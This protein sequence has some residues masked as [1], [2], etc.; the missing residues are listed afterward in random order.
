M[1]LFSSQTGRHFE[2]LASRMRP[3]SLDEYIGQ[4]HIVGPGRLLRRAIRADQLTSIIL[5]GPPGTG[6]TTLARVIA[7]TTKSNF[8]T[9]NAVLS[10]VKQIR[11]TVEKAQEQLSLYDQ[12]TILFVDEVHRWNK[13]QQDALLPWVENG[14]VIL[15]GATIENPYFEVNRALVSRSRIFQLKPLTDKN[16]FAI[17]RFTLSNPERGYGKYKVI[18]DDDALSHLVHV[19]NGD[20]RSL[21][22]ALELAVETTPDHFPPQ[23]GE[24]IHITLEIAEQSIQRK[25]VLYDKEGDYHFDTISAFIKSLR[26]SDPDAALYWLA[27]MIYAGEE[28][29]FI[30]R[31]MLIFACE[32][33]GMADPNALIVTEAAASAFER[34]GLPEGRFHLAHATLY[35]STC[36]KSNSVFGFFDALGMVE[37][38]ADMDVPDH[39]KDSN[40]DSTAFGHGQGYLYPHAYRDHWVAQQYLPASLQGRIFYKPG[41]TGYEK[42]IHDDILKKREAQLALM[43]EQEQPE[44]LTFSP[45]DKIRDKWLQRASSTKSIMLE[46]IRDEIFSSFSLHRHDRILVVNETGGL[47]LWEAV[48]KVPEGGVYALIG[49]EENIKIHTHY[50]ELLPDFEKPVLIHGDINELPL[51]S[52]TAISGDVRFDAII[53]RNTFTR[54]PDRPAM[55]KT[56][57]SLL[58]TNGV[59]SLCE[60]IPSRATRLSQFLNKTVIKPGILKKIQKAEE[61]LYTS[62]SNTLVNWTEKDITGFLTGSGFQDVTAEIKI[63]SEE[64]RIRE[65]DLKRWFT[66]GEKEREN[67]GSELLKYLASEEFDYVKSIFFKELAGTEK[68]WKY[69]VVF[70]RAR[71]KA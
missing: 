63:Y 58:D 47:L 71:K 42:N 10:G 35:L 17:V 65:T 30:F 60:T 44:V 61:S 50:A 7:N 43:I 26:G 41:D 51:Q 70:I 52:S 27:K 69:T 4:E 29:R 36:A 14:T 6:K 1:E 38:E 13:S 34:V 25:A 37:N 21:L 59:L 53:G 22:N 67:Y 66:T 39:L 45:P 64:R 55:C 31:R 20:A 2:P 8:V 49:N 18:I 5:Y 57:Y 32:D 15:I 28:P 12:K 54:T 11:E 19:A 48:R 33:V 16:L 62:G 46:N 3:L 40:R 24:T 56:Y 9:I 68:E 23:E